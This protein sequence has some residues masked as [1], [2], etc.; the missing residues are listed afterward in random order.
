[1][2]TPTHLADQLAADLTARRCCDALDPCA[3]CKS[4]RTWAQYAR[5]VARIPEQ[6]R[7]S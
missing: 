6:R 3:S 2:T 4:D 5:H 7:A 1:M